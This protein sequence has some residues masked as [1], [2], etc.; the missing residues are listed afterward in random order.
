MNGTHRLCEQFSQT[1][2]NGSPHKPKISLITPS[3]K[4]LVTLDT[5]AKICVMD[6]KVLWMIERYNERC[7]M[8]CEKW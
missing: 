2:S 1:L 5:K 4:F 6:W 8:M 7:D 3:V